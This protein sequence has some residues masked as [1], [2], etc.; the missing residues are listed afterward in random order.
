MQIPVERGVRQTAAARETME[1]TTEG[2][3]EDSE[4]LLDD[5]SG[6]RRQ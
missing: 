1:K 4:N 2:F 3:L 6:R 5:L